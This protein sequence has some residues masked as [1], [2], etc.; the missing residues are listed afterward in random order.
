M[1][2]SP[3]L[4]LLIERI[5]NNAVPTARTKFPQAMP[6]PVAAAVGIRITAV[7]WPQPDSTTLG[8]WPPSEDDG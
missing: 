8:S 5:S 1:N 2:T 4:T 7:C 3:M 6:T